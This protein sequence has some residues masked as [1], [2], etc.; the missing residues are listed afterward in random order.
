M[1]LPKPML[2]QLAKNFQPRDGWI[3]EIKWDGVR[4]LAVVERGCIVDLYD[5]RLNRISDKVPEIIGGK[6]LKAKSAILDGELIAVDPAVRI[7]RPYAPAMIAKLNRSRPRIGDP[8]AQYMVFDMLEVDGKSCTRDPLEDRREMIE[9]AW[10]ADHTHPSTCPRADAEAYLTRQYK[11]FHPLLDL[12]SR[13]HLEGLMAK[14]LGACYQPGKR[15]AD[16]L[17]IKLTKRE[18]FIAVGWTEGEGYRASTFGALELTDLSGKSVGKVGS[19]FSAQDLG[20]IKACLDQGEKPLVLVEYLEYSNQGK[21]RFPVFRQV[22][23]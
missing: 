3:Y 13:N 10:C 15:S 23:R 18:E 2:A 7:G 4:A 1:N 12:I 11:D 20:E 9:A 17:K 14:R 8:K 19:G 5:R 6:V 22:V 21:L 16:W